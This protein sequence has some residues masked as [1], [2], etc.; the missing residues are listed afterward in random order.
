MT[1]FIILCIAMILGI[2]GFFYYRQT[3]QEKEELTSERRQLNMDELS[4]VTGGVN[5]STFDVN[6]L[7]T[8]L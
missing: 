3:R 5:H 1:I 7:R 6:G 8:P 4:K 2:V